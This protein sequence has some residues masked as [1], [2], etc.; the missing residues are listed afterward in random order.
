MSSSQIG[1]VG[2]NFVGPTGMPVPGFL[3]LTALA[4][5]QTASAVQSAADAVR[6][7]PFQPVMTS[8]GP[9][10]RYGSGAGARSST[11]RGHSMPAAGGR[12]RIRS[13]DRSGGTDRPVSLTSTRQMGEQET[14]DW[15]EIFENLTSRV[16][17]MENMSRQRD[18]QYKELQAR[19]DCLGHHPQHDDRHR[20]VQDLGKWSLL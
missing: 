14:A 5:E 13:R 7:L 19:M 11:P 4:K 6:G 9:G 1:N 8:Q 20:R 18:S 10:V 16:A 15:D 2:A 3:P 17:A 12:S